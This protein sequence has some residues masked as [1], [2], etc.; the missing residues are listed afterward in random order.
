MWTTEQIYT[1]IFDSS[2]HD[3]HTECNK[4]FTMGSNI[5]KRKS[6]GE[7]TLMFNNT[8]RVQRSGEAAK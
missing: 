2:K 4:K 8:K 5:A 7:G 1:T 3:A 6:E